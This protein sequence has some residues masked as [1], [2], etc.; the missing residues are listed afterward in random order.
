M[1]NK[2]INLNDNLFSLFDKCDE[3][4]VLK[5]FKEVESKTDFNATEESTGKGFLHKASEKN[6]LSVMNYLLE[7]NLDIEAI[8]DEGNTPLHLAVLYKNE[9]AMD[10]LLLHN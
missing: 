4:N 10:K 8:D 1:N 2:I 6:F 5:A 9:Q 3:E 7:K